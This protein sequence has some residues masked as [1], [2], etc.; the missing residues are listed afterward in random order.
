MNIW[1]SN[2]VF[3]RINKNSLD[4]FSEKYLDLFSMWWKIKTI[5]LMCISKK[6]L[7]FL[8]NNDCDLSKFKNISVHAP[9]LEYKNN[10][11]SLL[12]LWQLK[13]VCKKYKVKNLV[14]HPTKNMDREIIS[15]LWLPISIENMDN[16]KS[17][18]K[19]IEDIKTIIDKYNFK[20]TI[21]LQ[22]CFVNDENMNLAIEFHKEF[23]DKIVEYH[24]SWFDKNFK[25]YPL[26][27]TKQ[28]N[29]IKSI[30]IK[31]IPIIIES[32]FDEIWD[33]KKELNFILDNSK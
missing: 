7:S 31:N 17:F 22:H 16:E 10:K 28:K 19:S 2:W 23:W 4:R 26:F 8:V 3:Y 9:E 33:H 6:E 32:W 15:K 21:D 12:V 25:H 20:L 18:W 30:M 13:K 14:F 1:F 5:E 24:I 11:G 29:I 27:K